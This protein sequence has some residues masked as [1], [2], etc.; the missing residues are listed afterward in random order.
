M[1]SRV[2]IVF[3]IAYV[4][5]LEGSPPVAASERGKSSDLVNHEELQSQIIT[6]ERLEA[7]L[8]KAGEIFKPHLGA[9]H[10]T[11]DLPS[12]ESQQVAVPLQFLQP[13]NQPYNFYLPL[14]EYD[15]STD[16]H[17]QKLDDKNR[18]MEKFTPPPKP[19]DGA[20]ADNFY[21]VKPRKSPKKFNADNKLINI[22]WYNNYEKQLTSPN[23][24]KSV[25]IPK[26][27][28]LLNDERNRI[29]FDDS[30][31]AVDMKVPERNNKLEK[32]HDVETAVDHDDYLNQG[33]E[34]L[35]AAATF[36]IPLI[37]TFKASSRRL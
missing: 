16:D 36:Q 37:R 24:H 4:A 23:S 5:I 21:D 31:F 26:D 15:E 14:F 25:N 2:L 20:V 29:N 34:D 35:I 13:P 12:A 30:F 6:I 32:P 19:K 27:Q 9:A 28:Y 10:Y 18:H 7:L 3:L 17:T 33:E 8:R 11:E 22:K 1:L